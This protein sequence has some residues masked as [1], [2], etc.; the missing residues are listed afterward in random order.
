MPTGVD[1][2]QPDSPFVTLSN[3][4]PFPDDIPYHSVI[5]NR[6]AA[7]T[8]GGTDGLVTYESSHL[9][10]AVSEKIVRSGHSSVHN[11]PLAIEEVRRILHEHL[12]TL[13]NKHN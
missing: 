10:G 2:L 13:K 3:R 5:G 12:D 6:K 4:I 11:H 7:D 9:E 1:G 8:P